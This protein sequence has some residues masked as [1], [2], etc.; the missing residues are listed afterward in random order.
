MAE[1]IT[2]IF[3]RTQA[4][5]EAAKA[6]IA[7]WISAVASGSAVTTED[8]KACINASDLNRIEGNTKYLSEVWTAI[9]YPSTVTTK[10]W[11]RNSSP[12]V[13]DIERMITN[14]QT[15]LAAF[16]GDSAPE[17]PDTML[18]YEQVNMIERNLYYL[19][20][21]LDGGTGTFRKCSTFA[22]G[23]ARILP[24]WG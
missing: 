22:S 24:L 16:Y 20:L 8:L 2:P 3:D 13:D 5:V 9:G 14:V 4:D 23:Q 12:D 7:G 10:T 17:L 18:D 15:V 19:K 6:K 11:E 1:W 21:L